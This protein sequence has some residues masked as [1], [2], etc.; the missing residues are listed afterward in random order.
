[1]ISELGGE[2]SPPFFPFNL[3]K[4]FMNQINEKIISKASEFV[5]FF[6]TIVRE[7][8]HHEIVTLKDDA[9]DELVDLIHTAH[10]DFLPDDFRYEVIHDAL[11][12]FADCE[13]PDDVRVEAD[14]YNHDLLRWLSSNLK[15]I[16]YC[17]EAQTEFGLDK[18]DVMTLITYG[19]QI[20]KNEIV[21]CVREEL[22]AICT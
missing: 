17:D 20:E 19:Q 11:C 8:S 12:A 4:I 14:I 6:K 22:I 5:P 15:R 13:N 3:R 10:G 7:G 9:P 18:S 1:M 2:K 21:S 16:G